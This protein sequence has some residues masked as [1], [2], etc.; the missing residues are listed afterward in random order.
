QNPANEIRFI[1][2][3]EEMNF[4]GVKNNQAGSVL[5]TAIFGNDTYKYKERGDEYPIIV[6]FGKQFK[7]KA[8]FD[9]VYVNSQKGMVALSQLGE[10]ESLPAT[11]DIRR[12]NKNRVTEIDINIGKSTIGPVQSKIEAILKQIE[13][14]PGYKAEF[15]GM[16]EIQSETTGEIAQAF[17]LATILTF[18]LLAAIMNSF[19]HPFTIATS[20][21]TSF[22]G[23]F[24]LLFLSGASMN[25]GAMLAF[26]MLVG[27]VVNNNILV[28]DPTVNRVQAGEDGKKVLLEELLDKKNMIL[29]TTIAII[30]GMVPQLWSADGMKS[31]MGAV[32]IGGMFASLVWTFCLTPALFCVM[33]KLRKKLH[34]SK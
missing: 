31:A 2:N 5:R 17:L 32:M 25:V 33:E 18:M 34:K 12:L 23:V 6:E 10:I 20:I 28:L 26:V 1:P 7:S 24:V 3:E 27:L 29:M 4:W 21:I 11:P 15:A 22:A 30:A 8:M 13:W 19:V 9:S 16:S 14:E